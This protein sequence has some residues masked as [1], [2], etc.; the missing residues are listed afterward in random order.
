MKSY[1][2]N[3]ARVGKHPLMVWFISDNEISEN[4]VKVREFGKFS[5][6]P[7]IFPENIYFSKNPLNVFC[8][9][10]VASLPEP[11]ITP[12]DEDFYHKFHLTLFYF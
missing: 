7:R 4:R 11:L 2:D 3:V 12:S 1:L 10:S 6:S 5:K 9:A 8:G